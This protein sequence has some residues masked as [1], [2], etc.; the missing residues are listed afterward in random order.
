MCS[1]WNYWFQNNAANNGGDKVHAGFE[2]ANTQRGPYLAPNTSQIIYA[3][4]WGMG[5][6]YMKG[7][8]TW[9][10]WDPPCLPSWGY[11][12]I[13]FRAYT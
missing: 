4:D 10:N 2:T 9:C 1:P 13:W 12:A 7:Q 5:G 11:S 8:V 6:W 3:S